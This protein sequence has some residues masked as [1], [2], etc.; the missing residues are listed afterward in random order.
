MRRTLMLLAMSGG[1]LAAVGASMGHPVPSPRAAPA[2]A[3]DTTFSP[4]TL[5]LGDSIFH[6]RAAGGMCFTCHGPAAKGTPGLA[7][8]L[9][10]AQ[11]LHGDGSYAFIVKTVTNGV[12]KPIQAM[13]PMP[14]KGGAKLT[15][16]QVAAVAAFVYSLR[17]AR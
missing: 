8:D 5:A 11:W 13:A 7:P 10:D 14:P 12:P 16:D 17:N 1:V 4:A 15:P 3:A 2:A 9:T 6:G